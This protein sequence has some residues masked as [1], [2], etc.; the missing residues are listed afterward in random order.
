MVRLTD[1]YY[2]SPALGEFK[3]KRLTIE[4]RSEDKDVIR[5]RLYETREQIKKDLPMTVRL[6]NPLFILNELRALRKDEE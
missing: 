5:L 1:I 3:L 6:T 4:Y 2:R